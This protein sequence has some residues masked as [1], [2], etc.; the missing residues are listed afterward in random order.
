METK[1]KNRISRMDYKYINDRLNELADDIRS[2]AITGGFKNPEWNKFGVIVSK[3]SKDE[4]LE[5]D[6]AWAK[7]GAL[8]ELLQESL[9]AKTVVASIYYRELTGLFDG[10]CHLFQN[11]VVGEDLTKF[12]K[13]LAFT[14]NQHKGFYR[15]EL[16][17]AVLR[18]ARKILRE[19]VAAGDFA[20]APSDCSI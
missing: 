4:L 11:R 1:M 18:E 20:S 12:L 15:T 8:G 7:S 2:G 16:L 14:A 9:D 13:R 3:M 6:L 17:M 10:I 5:K 19:T